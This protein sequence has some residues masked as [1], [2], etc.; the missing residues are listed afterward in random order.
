METMLKVYGIK[1]CDTMARAF[2]WLDER[3]V[4]YEFIDYKKAAVAQKLLPDWSRRAGWKEL[5]NTRGMMWRRLS[6]DERSDVD[7]TK[8]LALMADY[9]TLIK[10][11][12]ADNG[13]ELLV[14]FDAQLYAD[15]L[16]LAQEPR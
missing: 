8:A 3:G 6:D 2:A 5:L 1:N 16:H 7:E 12:L 9:P 11:P 14:G 13:S 10:R 4:A 15:L